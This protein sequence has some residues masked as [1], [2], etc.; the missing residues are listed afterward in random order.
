[1]R[2]YSHDRDDIFPGAI[3]PK[4][5][6]GRRSSALGV[7]LK[8]LLSILPLER[9]IFVCAQGGMAQVGF[10][11]T[12]SLSNRFKSL[13]QTLIILEFPEICDRFVRPPEGEE[14]H[15]RY[16]SSS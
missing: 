3:M 6:I 10:E 2:R 13:R 16:S 12:Q 1:M 4:D 11:V 15:R 8:N 14:S 9:F 7:R 5:S